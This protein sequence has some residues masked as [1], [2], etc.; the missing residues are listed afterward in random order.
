MLTKIYPERE[1]KKRNKS[2]PGHP[3]DGKPSRFNIVDRNKDELRI[4]SNLIKRNSK[5]K[6]KSELFLNKKETNQEGQIKGM[7]KASD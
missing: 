6:S 1:P 7:I 2:S 5:I 4:K 3:G